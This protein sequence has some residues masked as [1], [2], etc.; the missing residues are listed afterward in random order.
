MV[1]TAVHQ[2]RGHRLRLD[3]E[4]DCEPKHVALMIKLGWAK[5]VQCEHPVE[6]EQTYETRVLDAEQPGRRR[7]K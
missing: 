4:Y 6:R 1:S 5:P 3:E 7:R 2:Y